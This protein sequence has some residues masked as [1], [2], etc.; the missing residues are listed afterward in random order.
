MGEH[1]CN[2][3]TRAQQLCK[4]TW[5]VHAVISATT[6]SVHPCPRL[7]ACPLPN[8]RR[9]P[10]IRTQSRLLAA[11]E[12]ITKHKLSPHEAKRN[13]AGQ[14]LVFGRQQGS[15]EREFCTSTL[16]KVRAGHV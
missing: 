9:P 5:I 3:S 13:E 7:R 6:F 11:S 4:S 2:I 10:C 15:Q 16:P 1:A 8:S 14:I 12:T